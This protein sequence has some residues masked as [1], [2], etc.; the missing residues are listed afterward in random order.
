M[1]LE[2]LVR[3]DFEAHLGSAFAVALPGG[4]GL[5]LHLATTGPAGAG[6]PG[7]RAPFSLVFHGPRT[8]LLRQG[9]HRLEHSELGPLDLFLVPVGPRG[10]AM[11][12]EAIFS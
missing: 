10:D 12:Y 2:R 6:L 1:E 4:E 3:S 7:K 9:I 11:Q 5:D 8:P